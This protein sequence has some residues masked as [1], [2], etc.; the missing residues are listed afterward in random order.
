MD[1]CPHSHREIFKEHGIIQPTR[2]ER[3]ESSRP[4]SVP[5]PVPDFLLLKAV[6]DRVLARVTAA[7]SYSTKLE[8]LLVLCRICG[9]TDFICGDCTEG[10]VGWKVHQ[11][12]QEQR[13]FAEAMFHVLRVM[14]QEDV[15]RTTK[16]EDVVMEIW[17]KRHNKDQHGIGEVFSVLEAT[18]S[19][20]VCTACEGDCDSEYAAFQSEES[21]SQS[22]GEVCSDDGCGCQVERKDQT[23]ADSDSEDGLRENYSWFQ[24]SVSHWDKIG[25]ISEDESEDEC[26]FFP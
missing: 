4:G 3:T 20:S 12:F 21:D 5:E 2:A 15:D 19:D 10:S 9:H 13:T 25:G 14:V 26:G 17:R 1:A 23:P 8:V 7:S 24:K 22:H 6:I 11:R 16:D 18:Q